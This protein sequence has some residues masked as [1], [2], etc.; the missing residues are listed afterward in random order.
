M[1]RVHICAVLIRP[2]CSCFALGRK[3]FVKRFNIWT[4][5]FKLKIIHFVFSV[6]QD[7]HIV[8]SVN[9]VSEIRVTLGLIPRTC[10]YEVPAFLCSLLE[11]YRLIRTFVSS[12]TQKHRAKVAPTNPAGVRV[13][14]KEEKSYLLNKN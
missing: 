10:Q 6:Y 12:G 5:G 2:S 7:K 14:E 4:E 3:E 1:R 8:D 11:D 13:V 9:E